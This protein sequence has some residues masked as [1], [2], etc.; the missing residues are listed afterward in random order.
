MFTVA[1]LFLML[2][3]KRKVS[4]SQLR[5]PPKQERWEEAG[6]GSDFLPFAPAVGG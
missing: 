1:A 2:L 3:L 5:G 6:Y 4:V